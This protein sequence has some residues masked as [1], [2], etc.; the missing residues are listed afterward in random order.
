M[1]LVAAH[2]VSFMDVVPVL[3]REFFRSPE[4]N[5][6]HA[7]RAVAFGG[8][9]LTAESVQLVYDSGVS[10]ACSRAAFRAE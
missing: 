9:A 2:N 6:A 8:E 1:S 10:G 7:L 4:A 3:G 5:R